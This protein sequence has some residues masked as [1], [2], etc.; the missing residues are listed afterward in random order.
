MKL[1]IDIGHPGHV[2]LFKHAFWQWQQRDHQSLIV[3]R[4][5]DVTHELLR[6]YGL[7]FEAAGARRT[8][9]NSWIEEFVLHTQKL[10]RLALRF[11]PD[12]FVSV[13]SPS[14][15]WA[16]KL[17]GAL[18]IA[19]D[20]TEHA[21]LEHVLYRP[22]THVIYTP[23][24]FKK[25]LGR[26][27]RRYQGY[28]ELAYLHPN[29][30]QPDDSILKT[31]GLRVGEIFS[32][33]RFVSWKASHDIGQHGLGHE[34]GHR[35][36]ETLRS[37]GPVIVT[38]E[39]KAAIELWHHARIP[40]TEIHNLLYYASLYIGEGGTMATEAAL[41]GTPSIFVNTL[42][43]G[44]WE[45]LQHRYGLLYAYQDPEAA[46]Q[47]ARGFLA[48]KEI[49]QQWR[50]RRQRLLQDK[51]DVT[52]FMVTAIEAEVQKTKL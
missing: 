12:V 22:F 27:Q 34:G 17:V 3:A 37:Y 30:F 10:V 2:H 29:W 35:L 11:K 23:A 36:I 47:H 38:N 4:D 41:L 8:S 25:D 52:H 9:A 6:V 51:I 5:K 7:P 42:T 32:V 24:C 31:L 13:G 19:F 33:V 49:K 1:I 39:D 50:Q 14:A 21:R 18:N 28:H 16:S 26:K 15:A 20:D 48:D 44:N 40:P 45:E 43:G 46:T